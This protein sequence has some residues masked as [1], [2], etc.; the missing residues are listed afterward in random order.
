M[1][2]LPNWVAKRKKIKRGPRI[3]LIKK[4][5]QKNILT[6]PM[7]DMNRSEVTSRRS[8]LMEIDVKINIA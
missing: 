7:V 8:S 5:K 2:R 6:L 4:D 1:N 3:P